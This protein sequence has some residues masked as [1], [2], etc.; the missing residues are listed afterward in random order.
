MLQCEKDLRAKVDSLS[1]EKQERLKSLKMLKDQDQL[2]CD[3]MCL[4]PYYIPTGSTPSNDQ[5]KALEQHVN[6]LKT[7]KVIKIC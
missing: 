7:E 1:G 3:A 4:T 2:L 6:S 5:L